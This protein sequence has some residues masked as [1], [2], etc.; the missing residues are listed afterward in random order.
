MKNNLYSV[1]NSGLWLSHD[2]A[3]RDIF[4]SVWEEEGRGMGTV[5]HDWIGLIVSG[6]CEY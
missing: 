5:R 6:I 3:H 1:I 2:T 4:S